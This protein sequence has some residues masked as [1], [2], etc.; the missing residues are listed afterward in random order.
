M[1]NHLLPTNM[2]IIL[3]ISISIASL[4][5]IVKCQTIEYPTVNCQTISGSNSGYLDDDESR[6]NCNTLGSTYRMTSCGLWSAWSNIDGSFI[7]SSNGDCVARMGA[8]GQSDHYVNAV[9][10]C[11][12]LDITATCIVRTGTKSGTNDDAESVVYCQSNEQLTGCTVLTEQKNID[13]AKPVVSQNKCTA[14]N[15]AGGNGVWAY[16]QCCSYTTPTN[17]R[18]TMQLD[19]YR[20][21]SGLSGTGDGNNAQIGCNNGYFISGCS[22]WNSSPSL[23]SWRIENNQCVATNSAVGNGVYAYVICCREIKTYIPTKH[24]TSDPTYNPT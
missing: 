22:G 9:A 15:G 14:F 5:S 20:S 1:P 19:C 6:V 7:D 13:G 17:P 4:I 3:A 10:H 8:G 23:D 18:Y 21:Q 2:F 16:A 11:C 12:Q 24:P